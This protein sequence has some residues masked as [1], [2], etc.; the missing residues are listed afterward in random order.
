MEYEYSPVLR[1]FRFIAQFE[2]GRYLMGWSMGSQGLTTRTRKRAVPAEVVG[3]L[4]C[5]VRK[6]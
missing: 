6:I 4:S 1:K 3:G 5:L 2:V